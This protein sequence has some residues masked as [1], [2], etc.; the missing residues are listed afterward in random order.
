MKKPMTISE[1][2][3]NKMVSTLMRTELN[4][5][6]VPYA[7]LQ[8]ADVVNLQ[9]DS[10]ELGKI[11]ERE[12]SESLVRTYRSLSVGV[13]PGNFIDFTG[14]VLKKGLSLFKAK[15]NGHTIGVFKDH[16]RSVDAWIGTV[17]DSFFDKGNADI[18]MGINSVVS[19]DKQAIGPVIERG[20]KTRGLNSVSVTVDFEW[21]PSHPNME[22]WDFFN[23]LGEEVDGE[24]VR[25]VA[26]KIMGIYEIS[27]VWEG[28]DP[29]AKEVAAS[30]DSPDFSK[31]EN[32]KLPLA[33]CKGE[34]SDSIGNQHPAKEDQ[35][36]K[37]LLVLLDKL[38]L[39]LNEQAEPENIQNDLCKAVDEVVSAKVAALEHNA[40]ITEKNSTLEAQIVDKDAQIVTLTNDLATSQKLVEANKTHL[41]D[42]LALNAKLTMGSE[43]ASAPILKLAA[44]ST[45]E[46]LAAL[47]DEYEKR[48]EQLNPLRCQNCQSTQV[49]RQSSA[50]VKPNVGVAVSADGIMER[51]IHQLEEFHLLKK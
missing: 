32:N 33:A 20:I 3:K 38:G 41:L 35:M 49:S 30:A 15:N 10:V 39:T 14:P 48:A 9:N 42:K 6:A 29:F 18:P 22:K 25:V 1:M 26:T 19:Y 34:C 7:N 36:E 28:A 2:Q 21:T 40:A 45:M 4:A 46:E 50:F 12:D 47:N 51:N 11:T 27:L 13:I 23:K 37:I 43:D 24:V 17:M 8:N 16:R 44:K 31:E 5:V